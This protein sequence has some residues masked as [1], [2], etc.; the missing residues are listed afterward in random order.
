MHCS[1]CEETIQNALQNI[2]NVK[3]VSIDVASGIAQIGGNP[4]L[5]I[6]LS[7]IEK[8]GYS[9]REIDQPNL[10]MYNKTTPSGWRELRP[11]FIILSCIFF[12][13]FLLNRSM[14]IW[15]N[16]M[17]DFMGLF[18]IVFSLLKLID[19]R[20]FPPAFANY[21]PLAKKLPI[22]GWVYPLIE[23]YLGTNY[24][25]SQNIFLSLILTISLL[26][27]TTI[28]VLMKLVQKQPVECA[29]IGTAI[30][31]PLTKATLIENA[32]MIIMAAWILIT[33]LI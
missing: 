29:C 8:S 12:G 10:D 20:N 27:I 6:L 13:A 16:F 4:K 2:D 19:Y 15:S 25:L 11:L 17:M 21:D 18:F 24:L 33:I 3:S 14:F 23:L 30:K 7:A 26:G 31:L 1:A 9:A 28:G 22:Y 32:I 5:K